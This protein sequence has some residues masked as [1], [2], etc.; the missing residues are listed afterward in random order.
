MSMEIRT[1]EGRKYLE[2]VLFGVSLYV[3]IA[4]KIQINKENTVRAR[5]NSSAGRILPESLWCKGNN[6]GPETNV[7][8]WLLT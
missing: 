6:A 2:S 3:S 4:L 7:L 5:L 8:G 1:I